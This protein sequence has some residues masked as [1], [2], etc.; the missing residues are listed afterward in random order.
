MPQE[1]DGTFKTITGYGWTED[2]SCF[3][4][5]VYI[6]TYH[7]IFS[8][9]NRSTPNLN[10]DGYFTSYPS[11][12]TV[13]LRRTA[14]GQPSMIMYDYGLGKVIISSLYSDWGYAHSQATQDEFFI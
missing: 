7:Q 1:T 3:T 6:D 12:S 8:G 2:Q 13:L 10:V 11:N 9:Q 14:N 5:A 4:N